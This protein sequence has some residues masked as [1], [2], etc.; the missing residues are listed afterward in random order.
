M[1]SSWA[2]RAPSLP[3]RRF[4]MGANRANG[5]GRGKTDS[6]VQSAQTKATR[7]LPNGCGVSWELTDQKADLLIQGHLPPSSPRDRAVLPGP[8]KHLARVAPS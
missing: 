8:A 2:L 3:I 6:V 4:G 5:A 7:T 1:P